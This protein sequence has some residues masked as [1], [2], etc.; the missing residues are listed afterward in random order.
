MEMAFT[1]VLTMSISASWL[2]LAVAAL[3]VLLKKSPKWI[4]VALWALVALRL[5]CPFSL[6]STFS[7]IPEKTTEQIVESISGGYYGECKIYSKGSPQ[8]DTAVAD[9]IT[10]SVGDNGYHYVL[11]QLDDPTKPVRTVAGFF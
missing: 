7:L 4:H 8:Y 2:V 5:V 10:P 1:K 9:G 3:R 11:T 6:E